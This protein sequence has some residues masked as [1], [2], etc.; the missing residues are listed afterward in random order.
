MFATRNRREGPHHALRRG[1]IGSGKWCQILLIRSQ[2]VGF[3]ASFFVGY[4]SVT[5]LRA[6]GGVV[7]L[8]CNGARGGAVWVREAWSGRLVPQVSLYLALLGRP[9]WWLLLWL[10]DGTFWQRWMVC[11]C[12]ALSV[13]RMMRLRCRDSRSTHRLSRSR[14]RHRSS[15]RRA[16]LRLRGDAPLLALECM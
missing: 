9:R 15:M 1:R 2:W 16:D 3:L 8:S 5:A 13:L 12:F 7:Q 11:W 4:T 14:G 6:A 10:E